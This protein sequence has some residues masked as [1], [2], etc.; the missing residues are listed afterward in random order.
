MVD[1]TYKI[2]IDTPFG[3]KPGTVTLQSDGDK[4]LA[5]IDAPM[6]G[7]QHAAGEL[8]GENEFAAQGTFKIKL[9]GKVDYSLHG[10]VVGDDI[11][12][13]IESSKGNFELD[14][15]RVQ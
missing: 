10:N 8:V 3:R 12:V 9:I 1:G 2:E 5:D 4:V 15:R 7:Q 14:G 6:I 11:H 13:S